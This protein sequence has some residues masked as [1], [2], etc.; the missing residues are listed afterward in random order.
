MQK[1]DPIEL[2]FE[3]GS[4][5]NYLEAMKGYFGG[6]INDNIYQFQRGNT[7]IYCSTFVIANEIEVAVT[8]SIHNRSIRMNRIPDNTPDYLH[9]VI[10]HEGGYTQSY[11][12]QQQQLQADSTKGIFFYNGMFPLVAEFPANSTYKA[13]SFKFHKSA[14]KNIL[15]EALPQINKMYNT[16]EGIAYHIPTPIEVNQL[17]DDIM[18][19]RKGGFGVKAFTKA[20]ALEAFALTLKV[21]DQMDDDTLNGLHIADFERLMRIKEKVMSSLTI[22]IKIE[23]IA[24]EFAISVSKLNRD[25]RTL[26]DTT[27]Y[28]FYTLAKIDEAYRRLQSG[29]YSVTEVSYDMGY[30][31]PAKFSVMFKK[32]KGISPKNVIPIQTK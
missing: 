21:M 26:F 10:I 19:Y 6:E 8:D 1:S 25:F 27:I 30:A 9:L 31:N 16:E 3:E 17:V 28:K 22:P 12:N 29:N 7:S 23:E 14:L 18:H 2:N 15:P 4:F 13:L 11:K 5:S 24:E 32:V 20:R